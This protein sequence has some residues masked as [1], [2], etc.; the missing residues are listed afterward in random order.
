[1]SRLRYL[2]P[3]EVQFRRRPGSVHLD[4]KVGA[5]NWV[6]NV[7]LLRAFPLSAPRENLAIRDKDDKEIG[8]LEKID[9][10]DAGSVEVVESELNRRYFTPTILQIKALKQD[11]GMWK[12]DVETDRGSSDFFVRN[13]RD[14]A[15]EL[16]RGLW[17]ITSVDGGRYEIKNLDDLDER[18]QILIEQLL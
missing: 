1:M 18:S 15:Y 16:T 8:I 13:W 6:E 17:Q 5:E 4:V 2:E 12:F 3:Q 9:G 14:S 10:L 7:I 11:A